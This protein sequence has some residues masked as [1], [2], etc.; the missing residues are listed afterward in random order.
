MIVAA[1]QRGLRLG[2]ACACR[3]LAEF[4]FFIYIYLA[5]LKMMGAEGGLVFCVLAGGMGDAEVKIRRFEFCTDSY[6][7]YISQ[8]SRRE[9]VIK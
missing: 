1:A 5:H 8:F 2:C 4:I 6:I 3:E 9:S 7:F